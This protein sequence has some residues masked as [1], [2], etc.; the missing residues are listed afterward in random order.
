MSEIS[1]ICS[2]CG[3]EKPATAE[4]FELNKVCKN[5]ISGRCKKCSNKRASVWRKEHREECLERWHTRYST[6][7]SEVRS[8][9]VAS[10]WA[11]DPLQQK[12]KSIHSGIVLIS[13]Q[14]VVLNLNI[15]ADT[16]LVANSF[17][18]PLVRIELSL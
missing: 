9:R 4:Y 17:W 13:A 16:K 6:R 14:S 15:K 8:Q 10:K 12:A 3:L 5:G 18:H 1:K 7:H 2:V 11:A